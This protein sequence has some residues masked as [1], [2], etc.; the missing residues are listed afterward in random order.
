M[1]FRS[2]VN[3]ETKRALKLGK[4]KEAVKILILELSGM[5]GAQFLRNYEDDID[6]AMKTRMIEA[7]DQYL[8]KNKP[9]QHI[10]GYSYFY[11]YRMIVN[12]KVLIPRPETEELVCYVLQEYDRQFAKQPVD[13]VDVGTGS[14]AIA[15]ALAKEEPL[16]KMYATDISEEALSVAGENARNLQASVEFMA[17][18]M[19]QPLIEKNLK[20]D[21]LVSNPPYIPDT[22]YVEPIVKDNEP[23]IA[24]FGGKYGLY[25]YDLILSN[26]HKV[27]KPKNILAFEHSYSQKKEMLAMAGKYFPNGEARVIQDM[28]GKD[29][30]LIIVND[31]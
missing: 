7:V 22:E 31:H 28:N 3:Q 1:T 23:S 17:G 14:G 4:E 11:G 2:L 13:V 8:L 15:I 20:F 16:M 21:I 12:N 19:L 29:R 9:I 18:D 5:D 27:L 6:E 25:F 10:L 26:A 30:I 24:L